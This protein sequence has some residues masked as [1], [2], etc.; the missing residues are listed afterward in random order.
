M[1]QSKALIC[2]IF[3]GWIG[4]TVHRRHKIYW[5]QFVTFKRS[6]VTY[7]SECP[8]PP[9]RS[10]WKWGMEKPLKKIIMRSDAVFPYS[11]GGLLDYLLEEVI[12]TGK[13]LSFTLREPNKEWLSRYLLP[14]RIQSLLCGSP[15]IL[16]S[17]TIA[18]TSMILFL[19]PRMATPYCLQML[20]VTCDYYQDHQCSAHSTCSKLLSLDSSRCN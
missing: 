9:G 4:W 14:C 13:L 12:A 11:Q 5:L 3:L 18:S 10:L 20:L 6:S 8:V 2:I 1:Q 15:Y 16:G 19:K 17:T 7:C